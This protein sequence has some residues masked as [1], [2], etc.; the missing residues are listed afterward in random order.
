MSSTPADLPAS[1]T[2]ADFQASSRTD[3]PP[4]PHPESTIN[5][6]RPERWASALGGGA[7]MIYGFSRR[8][9]GGMLVGAA[10]ASLLYRGVTG[11]CPAYGAT[12]TNRANL[13]GSHMMS[14]P[15]NQG[16]LVE[17]A[18]TIGKPPEA[19]YAFWHDFENLP[20]FMKH[21][22]SVKVRGDGRSHW[23]AQAP[24]GRTVEWDAEIINE[25]PNRLIAWRSL[26][27]SAVNNAG[28]VRFD[29]APD[30]RGT[31]VSVTLN[32]APPGGSI[33]VALARLFGEEPQVQV[34]E[35]LRRFKG[36][37]EAG[38]IATIDGQPSGR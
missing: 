10:G 20:R 6:G 33:G 27:G 1:A 17:A 18:V 9:L 2:A 32:Y 37:M 35:D 36:L 12:G 24:A 29:P 38:E 28:S 7:L 5:V 13:S 11:H 26:A 30:G 22:K 31:E 16:R 25:E 15:H 21:L 8:S 34:D 14:V 23:T 3:A 19:L 4:S